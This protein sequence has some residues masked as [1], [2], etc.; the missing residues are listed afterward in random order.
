MVSRRVLRHLEA[1][2]TL[3]DPWLLETN[4]YEQER[5]RLM[6]DF[7]RTPGLYESVLEIGCAAG[8]FTIRLVGCCK[9]LRVVDISPQAFER[10]KHRLGNAGNVRFSIADVS[11]CY[12][13]GESY[14]LVVVSEVL[15]YLETYELMAETVRRVG[16]W[17][18]PHGVLI[19]GS[20]NDEI[21]S[22]WGRPG[23]ETTIR[24]WSRYL[25]EVDRREC[26]GVGP[27]EHATIVKF[28]RD[29]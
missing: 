9:A 8:A 10:C 22:R 23:A 3:E 19:F 27:C 14:D 28:V 6:L 13:W 11:E 1:N 20:M 25:R 29:E 5:Y 18:R 21:S 17:L 24:E 26:H 7:I 15:Y 12:D 2:L 16:S 4:P